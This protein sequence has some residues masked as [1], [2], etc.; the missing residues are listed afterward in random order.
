MKAWMLCSLAFSA[1]C[2]PIAAQDFLPGTGEIDEAE[3]LGRMRLE[4]QE[5]AASQNGTEQGSPEEDDQSPGSARFR[6]VI[7][8]KGHAPLAG[9]IM[10]T[11]N[12]LHFRTDEGHSR[13]APSEIR[14]L[15]IVSWLARPTSTEVFYLPHGCTLGLS[16]GVTIQGELDAPEWLQLAVHDK[17]TLLVLRT[18]FRGTEAIGSSELPAAAVPDGTVVRL[19]FMPEVQRDPDA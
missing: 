15:E 18:Y 9:A 14:Y 19:E 2:S 6:V 8:R 7:E 11:Q 3:I 4:I 12:H 17:G 16:T 5:P 1:F 10:L 13:V